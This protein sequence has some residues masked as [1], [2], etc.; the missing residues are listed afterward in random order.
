M[1]EE[2]TEA[3]KVDAA[4]AVEGGNGGPKELYEGYYPDVILPFSAGDLVLVPD[5]VDGVV[6]AYVAAV[7]YSTC[8]RHENIT[9][10]RLDISSKFVVR[11]TFVSER[12]ALIRSV[13][14]EVGDQVLKSAASSGRLLRMP[15]PLPWTEEDFAG[16]KVSIFVVG[17]MLFACAWLDGVTMLWVTC[18]VSSMIP[19]GG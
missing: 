16:T 7:V 8:Q 10:S 11:Q 2:I 5:M 18:G 4:M 14:K 15:A 9:V 12:I 17:C 19:K 1:Q 3:R 6:K 13:T